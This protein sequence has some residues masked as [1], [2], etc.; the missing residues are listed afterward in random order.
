MLYILA[1]PEPLPLCTGQEACSS[2]RSSHTGRS[3]C[4]E[5]S[6][7][8]LTHRLSLIA[9]HWASVGWRETPELSHSPNR[10]RHRNG[11]TAAV[12]SSP[13]CR[14]FSPNWTTLASLSPSRRTIGVP[15]E[16]QFN[17]VDRMLP[18]ASRQTSPAWIGY[19][20]ADEHVASLL[21]VLAFD[22]TCRGIQDITL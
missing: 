14:A 3:N 21:E 9:R 16:S 12:Q 22:E 8:S 10:N 18:S 20:K 17:F 1:M 6:N 5:A 13:D 15:R 4:D 2:G 19:G 7:H 11:I